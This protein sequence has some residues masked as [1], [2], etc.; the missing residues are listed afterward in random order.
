MNPSCKESG[1]PNSIDVEPKNLMNSIQRLNCTVDSLNNVFGLSCTLVEKLERTSDMISKER[2][3]N[4][5]PSNSIPNIVD[6]FNGINE[7]LSYLTDA[8]R[9]NVQKAIS[10]VE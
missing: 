8:I 6:L 5:I 2:A 7:R 10:M 1:G 4:C 9:N 3:G